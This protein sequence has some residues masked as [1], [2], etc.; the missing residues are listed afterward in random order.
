[1]THKY[2][3]FK[4]KTVCFFFFL[5]VDKLEKMVLDLTNQLSEEMDQRRLIEKELNKLTDLVTQV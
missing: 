3:M 5:Q 2:F 1:M 4:R